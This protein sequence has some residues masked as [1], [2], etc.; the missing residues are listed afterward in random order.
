MLEITFLSHNSSAPS[1][2]SPQQTDTI[3]TL[4]FLKHGWQR[5]TT[6]LTVKVV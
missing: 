4:A 6:E 2:A 3:A 5:S 1:T